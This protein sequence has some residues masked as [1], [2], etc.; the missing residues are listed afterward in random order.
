MS[1]SAFF[2]AS[3]FKAIYLDGVGN[4]VFL[5]LFFAAPKEKFSFRGLKKKKRFHILKTKQRWIFPGDRGTKVSGTKTRP[6]AIL[7]HLS[8]CIPVRMRIIL[9][10]NNDREWHLE[11]LSVT[12]KSQ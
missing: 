12:F 11:G 6:K 9:I 4:L 3:I 2:K 1:Q 8:I 7:V 5:N 10:N